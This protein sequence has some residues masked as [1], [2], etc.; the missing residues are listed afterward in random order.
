M[1]PSGF[2]IGVVCAALCITAAGRS[3]QAQ[4]SI[5]ELPAPAR[6][7]ADAAAREIAPYI[8][9]NL[10]VQLNWNDVYATVPTLPGEPFHPRLL[11]TDEVASQLSRVPDGVANLVPGDY[12][13]R[14]RVYCTRH[15]GHA[16][17]PE[18][19]L[20]APL[21]GARRD[22][23]VALYSRVAEA[24]APY[25]PVQSLSWSIQAGMRYGELPPDQQQLVDRLIPDYRNSL[26]GSFVDQMRDHWDRL[27]V[28]GL[29][30]FDSELQSLG[31]IGAEVTN[32]Q[33]ARA[34]ILAD[35]GD[36]N[37]L[38]AQLA[39][40]APAAGAQLPAPWSIVSPNVYMRMNST[41]AYG[42]V[43]EIDVRVIGD[44][45]NAPVAVPLLSQIAYPPNCTDCQPLTYNP[46]PVA[47]QDGGGSEIPS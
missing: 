20:L 10:P 14:V 45:T 22:A 33:A 12:R 27:G 23:L 37:A 47:P 1:R 9:Q 13:L 19:Y 17:T 24:R 32:L 30:S 21:R 34:T 38:S 28:L 46:E 11:A 36:F 7:G 3:A 35:A 44:A 42:S 41:T 8:Q 2:F 4:F 25:G 15:S 40:R 43:G 26:Q 6:L 18:E 39:P 31:P 16:R 5:P 29:P